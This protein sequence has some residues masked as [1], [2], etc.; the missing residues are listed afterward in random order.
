MRSIPAGEAHPPVAPDRV[1]LLGLDREGLRDFFVGL[2]E[3]PFRAAQAMKWLHQRQVGDFH[4]M[5]DLGKGLR[6][7]LEQV[8][9]AGLPRVVFD[10]R[11][12]DGTRKWLLAVDGGN[13]VE[14]VFIPE[15]D[16]GTLCV[17]S[18]V[19]CALDCTFCSTARQGF[20]RNLSAA[21]IIGQLA[22]A[23]RGLE[24]EGAG[25][26]V[27]NVV[28][29]GMGEPL[30]NF[31]NVVAATNLMVDA[32]AYGLSRRRVTLSTAGVV[33]ALKR[34]A[35]VSEISLAVSLHAPDDALRDVLVPINRKYPLAQLLEACRG[36]VRRTPH[37]AITWEYVML[38]GV[39]D[40]EAQ[41]RALARLLRSIPSKINLIPF[42]PFPGAGYRCSPPERI[43]RFAA[44]L[45]REGYVVTV[46]RTR[47]A[48]IDGACG[49]LVGN[50][51]DRR[52]P[53]RA[54][55][56]VAP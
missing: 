5:T 28:L 20:N 34:L 55:P 21:E 49:Q 48:D 10:Q 37:R 7:R 13:A 3:K 45:Q 4:A 51:L 6:G 41:A 46:R 56:A 39:N 19:G 35:E 25:R 40:S 11:S 1:N 12:R 32:D 17:S 52:S 27:T 44:L 50:V 38:D 22:L 9:E 23:V 54:P 42:N 16:R 29:M 2:G 30:A 14:T 33:P 47:G 26:R 43:E 15:A 24:E 53:G 36:Y 18:Q 31:R 8:A